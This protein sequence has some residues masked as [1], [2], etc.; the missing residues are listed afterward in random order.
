[1]DGYP[2]NFD[3]KPP[4]Y[5]DFPYMLIEPGMRAPEG[6]DPAML[7]PQAVVARMKS[8]GAI[9]VKTFFENDLDLIF[10]LPHSCYGCDRDPTPRE[11]P[12]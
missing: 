6:I 4:R 9:C 1:M 7:T 8:D 11:N 3:P 12:D 2:M 5:R 10:K